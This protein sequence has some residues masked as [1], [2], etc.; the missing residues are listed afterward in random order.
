MAK[1]RNPDHLVSLRSAVILGFSLVAA[2]NTGVLAFA[3]H[4]SIPEAVITGI[5]TLCPGVVTL[6]KL[7]GD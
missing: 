5:A 6:I 2:E 7:I 3:V 1:K 4:R